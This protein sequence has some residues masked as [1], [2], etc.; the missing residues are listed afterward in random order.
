[1]DETLNI[2][3]YR[4]ATPIE[5]LSGKNIYCCIENHIVFKG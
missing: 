3:A 2:A 4:T 5:L 1:M